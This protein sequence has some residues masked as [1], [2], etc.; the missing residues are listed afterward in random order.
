MIFRA[1]SATCPAGAG[2]LSAVTVSMVIMAIDARATAADYTTLLADIDTIRKNYGVPA[3]GFSL[4]DKNRV[5]W[6]GALGVTDIKTR[7]PVT[8][9]TRFRIGSITKAFTG[10]AALA[11]QEDG[12]LR[13]SDPIARWVPAGLYHNPWAQTHPIRVAHL[14]EHTA[15]FTDMSPA[16]FDHNIPIAALPALALHPQSRRARWPPG[17]HASYSNSGAGLAGLIIEQLADQSYETFVERRLL[18]PL[19]MA[20][21]GFSPH[22]QLAQ[23]Y[24]ADGIEPIPYWHILFRPAGAINSTPRDMAAFVRLLLNNGRHR[25]RQLLA[26]ASVARMEKPATTLAAKSGL[27]H[28][29]GLGVYQWL[30]NGFRFHGHG[31]D[32]D[33]YLA[34]FGYNRDSGLGYFVVVT[35]FNHRPLR[36]IRT[37]IEDH[38]VR[39]LP[40]PVKPIAADSAVPLKRY[41]GSYHPVTYR[42]GERP[43]RDEKLK[44]FLRDGKLHTR[45]NKRRSRPLIAV[46]GGHFRRPGDTVATMAFVEAQG[47]MYLQADFGNYRRER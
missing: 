46:N 17:Y 4:T 7:R 40:A 21:T 43:E 2:L 3:V 13:L 32:G 28:G 34:H 1:L 22:R 14:L 36:E 47:E 42:F 24:Q 25:G 44:V 5:L 9:Q 20:N 16:E 33:G 15:G 45:I 23:G 11:L 12:K 8:P 38:I 31:G 35:V 6:S 10:L 41:E 27:N 39:N 26:P 29:Y 37:K 30:H 19:A 18:Q